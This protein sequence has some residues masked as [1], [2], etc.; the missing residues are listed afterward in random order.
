MDKDE[1]DAI[2]E[3]F[4]K[5]LKD[6]QNEAMVDL[7]KSDEATTQED[8]EGGPQVH[9][10]QSDDVML[11]RVI[12]TVSKAGKRLQKKADSMYDSG[13]AQSEDVQARVSQPH[14][15]DS[16]DA[17]ADADYDSDAMDEATP[18]PSSRAGVSLIVWQHT[19]VG[20][21]ALFGQARVDLGMHGRVLHPCPCMSLLATSAAAHTLASAG[22]STV[23][24][25]DR[26]ARATTKNQARATVGTGARSGKAAASLKAQGRYATKVAGAQKGKTKTL[27][28]F[29]THSQAPA[30]TA[31]QCAL[32]CLI[33]IGQH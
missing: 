22:A 25:A 1:K 20:E 31:R 27:N 4:D 12:D 23:G 10:Q 9:A 6:T 21:R 13:R 16:T 17:D 26:S 18:G 30:A 3:A 11:W 19:C 2:K 5:S 32:P 15:W 24:A 33:C 29:M 8:A 7:A 28:G 14:E